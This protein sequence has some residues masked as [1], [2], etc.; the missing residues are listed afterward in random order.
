MT[1]FMNLGPL[2]VFNHRATLVGQDDVE[3]GY[4]VFDGFEETTFFETKGPFE[5]LVLSESNA[6]GRLV[7]FEEHWNFYNVMLVEWNRGLVERRGMG[8]LR[9]EG[10]HQ[11]FQ[12]GPV[13]KEIVLA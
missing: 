9:K 7:F 1:I 6:E 13:W 2:D 5:I 12:P 8:T 4:V 3:H 10:L 11:S